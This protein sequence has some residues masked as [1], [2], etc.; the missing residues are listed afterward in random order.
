[1][2]TSFFNFRS[3]RTLLWAAMISTLSFSTAYGI[4]WNTNVN[5]QNWGTAANWTPTTVPNAI[6]TTATFGSVITANRNVF[7]NGNF[8]VG[9]IVF[10]SANNYRVLGLG[11]QT[12][13][14]A[15][16]SGNASIDV[17]NNNGSHTLGTSGNTT[18]ALSNNNLVLNNTTS[19][20][21]FL[22]GTVTGNGNLIKT[23]S[24]IVTYSN[25]SASTVAGNITVTSGVL[26][27]G[28]IAD[29]TPEFSNIGSVNLN[30]VRL[31]N[32]TL[33]STGVLSL[34]GNQELNN[35]ANLNLNG[36]RLNLANSTQTFQNLTL[37]TDSTI[38]M[39]VGITGTFL[40][41]TGSVTR[42]AGTLNIGGWGG[43]LAGGG[44]DQIIFGT[45]LSSAFLNNVFWSTQ[46][47]TGARQLASGEIVP[48]PEPGSILGGI[49]LA[50]LAIGYE[51][52]RRRQKNLA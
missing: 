30:E 50:A 51:I 13:T 31:P 48:I 14:F 29:A 11:A 6:D 3:S 10:D 46:G 45:T 39:G 25:T 20:S 32:G 1:M 42:D 34:V 21:L 38:T 35:T 52:R 37:T 2:K 16:S 9:H 7:M 12:L 28:L 26:Q 43:S 27:V 23:G 18:I 33:V 5:N 40:N 44:A 47:I 17:I 15:V 8:T 22:E 4:D 49:G 41:F 19:G 36:G 24:G